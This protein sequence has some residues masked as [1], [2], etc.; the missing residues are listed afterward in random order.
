MIDR[1]SRYKGIAAVP[2]P[3]GQGALL[4]LRTLPDPPP[5]ATLWV[6]PT[7]T[8][9]LDLLAWRSYRDPTLFWRICDATDELD[10]AHTLV[11]GSRLPVPPGR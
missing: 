6:M 8:D 7:D 4:D 3:H 9:R 10:P 2:E 11:P 5:R 1:R